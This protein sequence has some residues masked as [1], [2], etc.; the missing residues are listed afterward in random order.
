MWEDKT[1]G[2][3]S[4]AKVTGETKQEGGKENDTGRGETSFLIGGKVM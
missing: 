1:M 2:K 4:H 3:A